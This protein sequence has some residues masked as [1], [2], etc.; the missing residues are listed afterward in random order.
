MFRIA[1]IALLIA[2]FMAA[3]GCGGGPSSGSRSQSIS[4]SVVVTPAS[5]TVYQGA[6]T[7][8]Q[9][10]VVGQSNQAVTWSVQDNFGTIDSTGLYTAPRDGYG[11]PIN[12]VATSQAVPTAHREERS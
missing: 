12:I 7:K 1:T 6:T 3:S 9:A 8:F 10:Q 11:G 4:T 5:A 2:M